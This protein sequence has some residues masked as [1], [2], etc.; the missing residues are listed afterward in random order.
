MTFEKVRGK[1]V[2]IW[3]ARD[4]RS[5][6]TS[7][8]V[9]FVSEFPTMPSAELILGMATVNLAILAAGVGLAVFGARRMNAAPD[10]QQGS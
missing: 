6:L 3:Y 2:P 5:F 8:A 10:P 7:E 1:A 9:Q 4:H